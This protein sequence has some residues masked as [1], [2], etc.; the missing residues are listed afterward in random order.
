MLNISFGIGLKYKNVKHYDGDF[1]A[2]QIDESRHFNIYDIANQEMNGLIFN[3]PAT[4][5]ISYVF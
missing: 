4:I 3:L 1:P 5:K 2:D